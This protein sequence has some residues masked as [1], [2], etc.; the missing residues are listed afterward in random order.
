M[1]VRLLFRIREFLRLGAARLRAYAARFQGVQVGPKCLFG[2]GVRIDRPWTA[3]FGARCVLEPGV[4]IDTTVDAAAFALGEHSFLG[5]NCHIMI[6]ERVNIGRHA[7]IGDGVLISD[8]MHNIAAGP[9]IATQ[10]CT[11]APVE[12]G[13]DVMLCVHSVVLPGVR[14]GDGAVVGAGAVVTRDVPANAVV[15]GVPA[16][17]LR[18]RDAVPTHVGRRET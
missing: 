11:S 2:K 4:W 18:M 1:S 3:A 17:I 10:G 13:D 9:L 5:R 7:L 6:T 15:A 8:H 12:I 14:I 16:A